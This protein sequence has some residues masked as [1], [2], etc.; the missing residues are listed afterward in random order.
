MPLFDGIAAFP[1][2]G[3][4]AIAA[5]KRRSFGAKPSPHHRP[6]ACARLLIGHWLTRLRPVRWRA[7]PWPPPSP[8]A[9]SQALATRG[10]WQHL[11]QPKIGV[12]P[13]P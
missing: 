1:A 11:H 5:R 6:A 4:V 9:P 12:S 3:A 2:L 7:V 8:G 10:P 13:L